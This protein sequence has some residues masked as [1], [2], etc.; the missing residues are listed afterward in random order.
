MTIVYT[1]HYIDE[2]EEL[3]N[4]VGIIDS[5]KL[6]ACGN[7]NHLKTL[8]ESKESIII[9]TV[10]LPENAVNEIKKLKGIINVAVNKNSLNMVTNNLQN[11]LQDILFILFQNDTEIKN[12]SI[13]QPDLESIYLSLTGKN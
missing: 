13:Q 1:T 9:D 11:N 5:G 6:I 7:K 4:R 8:I 2:A 10:R 12:I 3:C